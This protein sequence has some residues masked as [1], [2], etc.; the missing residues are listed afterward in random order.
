[1]RAKP[2]QQLSRKSRA[3]NLTVYRGSLHQSGLSF[4]PEPHFKF[5]PCLQREIELKIEKSR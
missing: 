5:N 1:M 3:S 4:N 2:D